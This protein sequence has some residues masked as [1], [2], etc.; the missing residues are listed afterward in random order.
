M[1]SKG[2][3][4]RDRVGKE[5][6][7]PYVIFTDTETT[8][9]NSGQLSLLLGCYEVWSIQENGLPD[10]EIGRGDYYTEGEFYDL[11]RRNMPCRLVAHNWQF[12][13][14]VLRVGARD[15]MNRY[16]Y[17]IDIL[18][19]ILPAE[20]GFAPF[21]IRLDFGKLGIAEMVCNTNYYKMPLR[22]IG[23]SLGVAKLE[24]PETEDR[25]NMLIYCR[26]DVEILRL[27]YFSLFQITQTLAGVTPGITAAMAAKRVF[28]AGFYDMKKAVQGTQHIGYI[29]EAE[30]EA[31][32]GGRTD[33]FWKGTPQAE[34]VLKYDINSLY[35]S[36]MLGD[37]PI[38]YIQSVRGRHLDR[39]LEDPQ[40]IV[41]AKVDINIEPESQYG[42]LGLEGVK[43]EMGQLIFAVGRY[44]TWIW[45]PLL[46]IA[47][48]YGYIERVYNVALY[49]TEPIFDDYINRLYALRQEYRKEG[50]TASDLLCKLLMNSLYGKFAQR[51]PEQW[52]IVDRESL[53]YS[54]L[55]EPGLYDMRRFTEYFEGQRGEYWQI[56][57]DL[58]VTR[59]KDIM[60]LSRAAVA[61]IAGYITAKGRAVLWEAMATVLDMGGTLYMCDT[62]SIVTDVELPTR[63]LSETELGKFKLEGTAAGSECYFFAPKHYLMGGELKLK[64]VRNPALGETSHDQTIFPRFVTDLLSRN[65]DRRTRLETG[66]KLTYIVKSPTGLN[67]KRIERGEGMPTFPIILDNNQPGRLDLMPNLGE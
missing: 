67:L 50:N 60:P 48:Q 41:M 21:F 42:F 5:K 32:H 35:P 4:L 12:D 11:V 18:K 30:R 37:V 17:D 28:Q 2:W 27:A 20:S 33:V 19:S 59:S 63:F 53:E 9:D 55:W 3:T 56:E 29:N 31:Y 34:T 47:L 51:Q 15:N 13:A 66:G 57:N 43:D 54:V 22:K 58:F 62:D 7:P 6:L 16:E 46:R 14:T 10:R 65:G 39:Y 40:V 24:M 38:R 64:G 25:E 26:R 36:C 44:R 61:S 23:D 1:A 45:E 49:D 8:E 52:Q